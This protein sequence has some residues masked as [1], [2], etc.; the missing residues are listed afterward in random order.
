MLY[1]HLVHFAETTQTN[2]HEE[3]FGEV[4][5]YEENRIVDGRRAH[6]EHQVGEYVDFALGP[7]ACARN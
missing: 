3:Q 6:D 4:V 5:E 7:E 2:I 1:G